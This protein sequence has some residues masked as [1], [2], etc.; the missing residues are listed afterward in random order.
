MQSASNTPEPSSTDSADLVRFYDDAYSKDPAEA[1]LYARWR[2][3]GAIGKAEP[4]ARPVCPQWHTAQRARSRSAVAMA[5]CSASCTA[6]ASAGASPAWR[7]LEAAVSIA[8]SPYSDRIGRALRRESPGSGATA[9]YDLAILS[10]VLE[11]VPDPPA[12]LA[13]VARACRAVLIEVPLEENISARRAPKREHA[14]EVGHLQRL[15]R[16]AARQ[17]VA[18]AGLSIAL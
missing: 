14:E 3:L 13:E 6:T 11:H 12:L 10:H 15:D 5:R 18:R 4:R 8:R 17:I 1:H 2:A 9:T 16:S 7:S